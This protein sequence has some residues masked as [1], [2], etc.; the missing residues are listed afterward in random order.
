MPWVMVS[1]K[2]LKKQKL[3]TIAGELDDF[4]ER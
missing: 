4:E 1:M 2:R 3:Y